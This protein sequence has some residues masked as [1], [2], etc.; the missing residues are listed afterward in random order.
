MVNFLFLV[1]VAQMSTQATHFLAL[2]K[3]LGAVRASAI[4]TLLFVGMTLP[5]ASDFFSVLHAVCFGASFVGMSDPKRLSVKQLALA[6]FVFA[7]FFH[8]FIHYFKGLGG[9]LGFS[10]FMAC[11]LIHVAHHVF[12]Q[13]PGRWR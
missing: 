4:V 9:A 8:F 7:L 10:A 13:H 12:A 3:K 2:Q 6:S 1:L 11:L 5:I